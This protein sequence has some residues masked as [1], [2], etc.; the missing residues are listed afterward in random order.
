MTFRAALLSDR[1][2]A[3]HDLLRAD[4]TASVKRAA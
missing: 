1:F 3:L 2:E 4:Y